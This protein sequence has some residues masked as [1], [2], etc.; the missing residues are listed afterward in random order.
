LLDAESSFDCDGHFLI[1]SVKIRNPIPEGTMKNSLKLICALVLVLL[2]GA[3]QAI[4][5]DK[6]AKDDKMA[7]QKSG[8]N[9]VKT[10]AQSSR[11]GGADTNIKTDRAPND[12]SN[13][14]TKPAGKGRGCSV[15]VSNETGWYVD[16]YVNGVYTG[17]VGPWG[18]GWAYP[19]VAGSNL[20]G[21][22]NFTDGSW[23]Y[24]GPREFGCG[25]GS[26][27]TWTITP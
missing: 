1:S 18:S 25:Q 20:Y 16:I 8:K 23:K 7:G 24:W 14:A 10:Q 11:G 13:Q 17:T 4:A 21:R 2:F 19:P 26:V 6:M 27:N 15:E 5:Q 12:P 9:A 3:T 22:A